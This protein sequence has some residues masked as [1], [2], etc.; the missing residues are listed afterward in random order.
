MRSCFVAEK[1]Q[2]SNSLG[3][4][5]LRQFF[6]TGP[7]RRLLGQTVGNL[8][9]GGVRCGFSQINYG[10][11]RFCAQPIFCRGGRI[12]G[13][14]GMNLEFSD[15]QKFVQTTAR[16]FLTANATLQVDR[17]VFESDAS[18]DES[19]KLSYLG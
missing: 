4:S 9:S 12:E 1:L 7:W 6:V 14:N 18:Y 16:E 19:Q 13:G 11:T 8:G 10:S 15:D 3:L 5:G 2:D 17:A